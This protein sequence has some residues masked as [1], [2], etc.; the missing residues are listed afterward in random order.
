MKFVKINDSLIINLDK[1]RWAEKNDYGYW[2][3][4]FDD[5][6]NI[7]LR[8]DE[9]MRAIEELSTETS[10]KD[11]DKT[12]VR[13]LTEAIFDMNDCPEWAEYA[14]VDEDGVAYFFSKEP[15]VGISKFIP[16]VT[17]EKC[18]QIPTFDTSD[19]K[20]SLVKRP[21]RS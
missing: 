15:R 11:N 9:F 19:W 20:N 7:K 13:K 2:V 18:T 16:D 8:S 5:E 6:R 12:V 4:H 3:V 21:R 10:T 1:I 17:D 14:A